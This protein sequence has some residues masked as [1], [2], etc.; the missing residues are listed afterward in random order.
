MPLKS[1]LLML[2]NN[3]L[4]V[5]GCYSAAWLRGPERAKLANSLEDLYVWVPLT[6]G[7]FMRTHCRVTTKAFHDCFPGGLSSVSVSLRILL[8]I[9]KI[10]QI[11]T[12]STWARA[13]STCGWKKLEN[14]WWRSRRAQKQVRCE[15]WNS[16]LGATLLWALPNVLQWHLKE[17]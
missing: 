1:P 8:H 15:K 6:I 17:A 16:C 2:L 13:S 4:F 5:L 12:G 7:D 14:S 9:F 11:L 3:P 10:I